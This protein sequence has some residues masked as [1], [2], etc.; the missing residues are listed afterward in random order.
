M[1]LAS[2]VA[3][4]GAWMRS[5]SCVTAAPAPEMIDAAVGDDH[6]PLSPL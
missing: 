6:R 5:A 2:R 4:T 1:C 3:T